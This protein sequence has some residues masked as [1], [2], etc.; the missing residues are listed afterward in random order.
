MTK[1]APTRYAELVFNTPLAINKEAAEQAFEFMRKRLAD[2]EFK[3]RVPISENDEESASYTV[4]NGTAIIPITG[5]LVSK[6]GF[7]DALSDVTSYSNLTGKVK[8]ALADSAVDS[9]LLDIDSPGGSIKGLVEFTDFLSKAD[10]A[11]PVYAFTDGIAYSA[12]YILSTGAREFHLSRGARTANVGVIMS[13][14]DDTKSLESRG[15]QVFTFSAG[16][17]KDLGPP[18]TDERAKV[19]Q[20]MVDESYAMIVDLVAGNRGIEKSVLTETLGAA[21]LRAEKAIEHGLADGVKTRD[22]MLAYL[23]SKNEDEKKDKTMKELI[24]Q[25][26]KTFSVDEATL[27][28]AEGQSAFIKKLTAVKAENKAYLEAAEAIGA[29]SPA[30]LVEKMKAL[31]P[32]EQLSQLKAEKLNLEA[33]QYVGELLATGRLPKSKEETAIASYIEDPEKFKG[34]ADAFLNAPVIPGA[35]TV[36][37]NDKQTL[38]T[39][40]PKSEQSSRDDD[41]VTERVVS[42]YMELN[43]ITREEALEAL[44]VSEDEVVKA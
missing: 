19:F 33:K 10:S 7:M 16:K 24:T 17:N 29:T 4:S 5:E 2:P 20:S 1:K 40:A 37:Q 34:Y 44:G 32:A 39:P 26:A 43:K 23:S 22:E 31:V 8:E 3:G 42:H 36:Q 13:L 12:A 38:N 27:A 18:M 30:E 15:Y 6:G 25:L 14:M 21:L 9:I 41:A 35:S 11:K 28:T